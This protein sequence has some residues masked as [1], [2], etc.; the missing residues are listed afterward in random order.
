MGFVYALMGN[1]EEAIIYFHKSLAI[2]RDCIVTTTILKTCIEDVMNDEAI[3]EDICGRDFSGTTTSSSS[4]SSKSA[5]K[6]L[7]TIEESPAKFNCMKLK[8]DEEDSTT[9]PPDK[10]DSNVVMDISMDL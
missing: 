3:I 5:S 8:F 2:N 9:N 1:L 6:R 4:S 10:S 7:P